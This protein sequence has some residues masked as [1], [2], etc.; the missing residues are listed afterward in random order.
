MSTKPFFSIVFLLLTSFLGA[1]NIEVQI[2]ITPDEFPQDIS[3]EIRNQFSEVVLEGNL[4]GCSPFQLCTENY[5]LEDK[6]YVFIIRDDFGDGINEPGGFEVFINGNLQGMGNSFVGNDQLDLNCKVGESC[7]N[8][9]VLDLPDNGIKAPIDKDYW[10]LLVPEVSG[11]YRMNTCLNF[12]TGTGNAN[13]VMWVYDTCDALIHQEGAEGALG[14][15]EDSS[16]CAPGSGFN[17]VPLEV[18]KQYLIRTRVVDPWPVDSIVVRVQK[19]PPLAG[20]TDPNA[21]NFNPFASNDNG[22]CIYNNDCRPDLRLDEEELVNSII[23]DRVFNSDECLVEEGCLTGNGWRDVIKFST[24]IDNIGSADYIVGIPERNPQNFS[25]E[26]CHG[27]WH[28]QGY[29]EYLLFSGNGQ[30]EPVGFKNGFCVLD[31]DCESDTPKYLCNYMGIT[32]GCSD[33]Y[34]NEIDCQWID[35]TDI[36]DGNYTLVARVNWNR[37][38]DMR[39]FQEVTYD[40]NWGQ[41]CINIDRSSG[42]LKVEVLE[43]CEQYSDCLGISFGQ[44]EIDCNGICGGNAEFGDLNDNAQIDEDDIDL[45]LD[46]VLNK[47]DGNLPCADLSGD[48]ALSIY[49]VTLL[50]ECIQINVDEVDNPFHTHCNFPIERTS[51]VESIELKISTFDATLGVLDLDIKIPDNDLIAYQIPFDGIL[52]DSFQ[53]LYVEESDFLDKNQDE[54]IGYHSILPISRNIDFQPFLRLYF[55]VLT[56]DSLCVS[57]SSEFVNKDYELVSAQIDGNCMFLTSNNVAPLY[58]TKVNVYPNPAKEHFYINASQKISSI[59]IWNIN[60]QV[61]YQDSDLKA[62]NIFVP[63]ETLPSGL[64]V[65]RTILSNGNQKLTNFIVE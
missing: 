44:A 28:H 56:S 29:A 39:S 20:C 42:E 38:A 2:N 41:V 55:S 35:I 18:G 1:Q 45:Y 14:Y 31:L 53:K 51:L 21:C 36:A 33:I 64:Y 19:L 40:N 10:F 32:A 7:N 23:L 16:Q 58:E 61:V 8:A 65:L 25:K 17:Y 52:I 46:L 47:L 11:L 22:S 50:N 57:N 43:D 48:D 30:P 49:D 5:T 54:I 4:D 59:K 62:N 26:N 34:D 6:C 12:I 13:T 60:G 24:K 3:W 9:V 27:H 63:S 37:L 15:S